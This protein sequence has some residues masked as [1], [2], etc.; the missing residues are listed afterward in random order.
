MAK[1]IR[2]RL[3]TAHFTVKEL[4]CRCGRED[5]DAK[6]MDSGF[7]RKL[8]LLRILWGKPMVVTS[9]ARC[10]FWNAHVGGAPESQHVHGNAADI[11]LQTPSD[12]PKLAALAE[13]VG[14]NGIGLASGFIHVDNRPKKARWTY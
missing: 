11:S 9:G 8:E 2:D 1:I 13:K 10:I 6:P 5:C 4:A 7:M 12:G 3:L 14:L